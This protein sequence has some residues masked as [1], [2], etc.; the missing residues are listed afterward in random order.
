MDGNDSET[1]KSVAN[2]R[3]N[4]QN[5]N[6]SNTKGDNYQKLACLEFGGKT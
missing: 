5:P 6:H 4:N 2:R 3:T 1:R